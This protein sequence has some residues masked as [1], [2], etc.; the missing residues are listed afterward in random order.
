LWASFFTRFDDY[1]ARCLPKE[2]R[3]MSGTRLRYST[4]ALSLGFVI[5]VLLFGRSFLTRSANAQVGFRSIIVELRGDPVV[6]ARARAQ[7]VGRSFNADAYSQHVLAEQQQFLNQ[8]TLAGESYIISSVL[9]PNGP[10]ISLIPFRYSYVF[11]GIAL[12]L[13]LF[14]A[15]EDVLAVLPKEPMVMHLDRAV[16]TRAG[17]S[18]HQP[19]SYLSLE[20]VIKGNFPDLAFV[21][22]SLD[23]A[24]SQRKIK[25]DSSIR[26]GSRNTDDKPGKCAVKDDGSSFVTSRGP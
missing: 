9:A 21:A 8:L 18:G 25:T 22:A 10:F 15:I 23:G 5:A 6:V 12:T 19:K 17:S 2:I 24:R 14:N 20:S 3:T 7:A 13:P 26:R 16:D 11:K 4:F 1:A